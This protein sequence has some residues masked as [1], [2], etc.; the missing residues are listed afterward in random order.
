[1]RIMRVMRIGSL[2]S[3]IGGLELG[4]ERAGVGHVVFQVEIDPF[5]R[6]VLAKHWPAADRSVTDVRKATPDRLAPIDVLCGGFPCQDI[7]TAGKGAGLAGARSGLWYEYR[8]AVAA[9]RPRVAIVENVA[10]G[11]ARWVPFVRS[12]L[13][14]LGYETHTFP[15]SAADVGAPHRRA[16]VF[17]VAYADRV[18][19]RDHEQRLPGG[20]EGGVRNEGHAVAPRDGGGGGGGTGP[21]SGRDADGRSGAAR[22]EDMLRA[23]AQSP[24]GGDP[25]GISTG[26]VRATDGAGGALRWPAGRGE[27]QHVWEPPRAVW[28]DSVPDHEAALAAL[29]NSVVPACA[30]VIGRIVV[31]RLARLKERSKET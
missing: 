26:L 18:E 4:L 9:F 22:P 30:E 6:R 15:V 20:R 29:G 1:M 25:D 17:L 24:L 14:E 13:E 12:D 31:K 16:R 10:S 21:P 23:P 2:F 28:R 7:S 3:G 5:C 8:R 11:A 19:L 27:P